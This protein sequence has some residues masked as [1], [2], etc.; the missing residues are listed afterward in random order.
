MSKPMPNRPQTRMRLTVFG[1]NPRY[2]RTNGA[3]INP[4]AVKVS[5]SNGRRPMPLP[6]SYTTRHSEQAAWPYH[7]HERHRREQHDVGVAGIDHRRDADDL[8]G[9]EPAKHGARKRP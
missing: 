3:R 8:A 1:A 9:N 5:I 4:A 7:Q 2:G 6:P